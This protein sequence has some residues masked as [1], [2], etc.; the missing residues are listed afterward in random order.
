MTADSCT[1][2]A[3][4]SLRRLW[5]V[6]QRLM[7]TRGLSG[8]HNASAMTHCSSSDMSMSRLMD[9]THGGNS[10]M[11]QGGGADSLITAPEH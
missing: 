5:H 8:L 4:I 1:S 10:F 7:T 3:C 2:C 11:L 9:T 6:L